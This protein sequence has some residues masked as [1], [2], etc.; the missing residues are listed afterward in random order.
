MNQNQLYIFLLIS[1]HF[2]L[3]AKA[4]L[5]LFISPII[6]HN[7]RNA[8]SQVMPQD[9]VVSVTYCCMTT[10][11]LGTQWHMTMAFIPTLKVMQVWLNCAPCVFILRPRPKRQKPLGAY[12]S[13]GRGCK[14]PQGIPLKTYAGNFYP[15]STGQINHMANINSTGK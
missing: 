6:M 5:Q 9:C 7:P 11:Q 8:D 12:S 14:F 10:N 4:L 3:W 15:H 1:M 2:K 13:H